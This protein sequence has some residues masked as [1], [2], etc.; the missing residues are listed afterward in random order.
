M[1][2]RRVWEIFGILGIRMFPTVNV[3]NEEQC[4][5]ASASMKTLFGWISRK[6]CEVFFV[7]LKDCA[8]KNIFSGRGNDEEDVRIS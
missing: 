8:S 3:R 4:S 7:I 1:Q 5:G 2:Y 6:H